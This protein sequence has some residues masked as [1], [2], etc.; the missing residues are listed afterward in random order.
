M[1][2]AALAAAGRPDLTV[3]IVTHQ[4]RRHVD[5]LLASLP[6]AVGALDSELVVVDNASTDGTVERL[7]TWAMPMQ[8]VELPNNAGFAASANLGASLGTGRFVAF[9]NPDMVLGVGCLAALV[10]TCERRAGA[11]LVGGRTVRPDGTLEPSSCWGRPSAWSTFCFA[12]G[13]STLLPGRRLFD[14]E[15][16][17]RWRRDT[18]REVG[19]VTGCLLA[20]ARPVWDSLAGFDERFWMFGEDVDLSMRARAAGYRPRITP[21]AQAVH[22]VGGSASDDLGARRCQLAAARITLLRSHWRP[23]ASTALVALFRL[24]VAWRAASSGALASE[25]APLDVSAA[26]RQ[27]WVEAWRQRRSWWN[28]YRAGVS[29]GARRQIAPAAPSRAKSWIPARGNTRSS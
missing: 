1:V 29:A 17:G 6:A 19:V 28:G 3:V 15:S 26:S 5:G 14:P 9:V 24:G 21:A 4:S 16:L 10:D 13:L 25:P 11:G 8:L 22:H 12:T 2:D 7:A 18:E 23:P 27:G 20:V